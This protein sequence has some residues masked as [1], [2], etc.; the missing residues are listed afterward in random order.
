MWKVVNLFDEKN[1]VPRGRR[2]RPLKARKSSAENL[3]EI[4]VV[5][6]TGFEPV[7]QP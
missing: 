4:T 7:F 2:F 3:H 6:P 1:G 5:A